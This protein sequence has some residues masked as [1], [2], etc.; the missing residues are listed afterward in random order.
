MPSFT[1]PPDV[2][3]DCSLRHYSGEHAVHQHDGH[4]QL[5]YA[6]HGR[7]ELEVNGHAAY[8]DTASGLLLPP[9]ARHAYWAAHSA[10]VLVL[11]VQQLP[12]PWVGK[13]RRFQVPTAARCPAP[14]LAPE[15]RLALLL[16]A[17]VQLPRRALDVP[18]VHSQVQAQLAQPWPTTR[19]AA[20]CHLSPARFHA[21][22]LE[23]TGQTPQQW[24]RQLRLDAAT[25][26][27]RRGRTLE[28]SATLCGYASASALAYALR[29]ERGLGAKALRNPALLTP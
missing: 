13:L 25:R 7:M 29:R 2:I 14:E 24:L 12:T 16:Q 26:L 1:L 9:G 22:W 27:L 23:A 11:D 20:L 15:Q 17:P 4:A 18:A 10:Q 19:L 21:R 6:L 28:A 8:V 5:L 3:V